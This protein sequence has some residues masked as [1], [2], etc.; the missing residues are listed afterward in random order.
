MAKAFPAT[1]FFTF[2]QFHLILEG[3]RERM[4][5]FQSHLH[6]GFNQPVP[7]LLEGTSKGLG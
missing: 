6:L 3:N 1:Y 4:A 7:V 2:S 5:F